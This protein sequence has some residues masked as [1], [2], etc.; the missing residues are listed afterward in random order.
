MA[1]IDEAFEIRQRLHQIKA[2]EM[3]TASGSVLD[4]IGAE[5]SVGRTS[6]EDDEHFRHRVWIKVMEVMT[7]AATAQ[8]ERNRPES[9]RFVHVVTNRCAAP[10]QWTPW[11]AVTP[12]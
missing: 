12:R 1:I 5:Y 7:D 4:R 8:I 9:I 3:E 11:P 6:G 10:F 2:D